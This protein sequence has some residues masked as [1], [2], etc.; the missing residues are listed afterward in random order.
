MNIVE[1][2]SNVTMQK[3][4]YFV[5]FMQNIPLIMILGFNTTIAF[6]SGFRETRTCPSNALEKL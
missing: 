1:G 6:L 3:K 4:E 2:D 5:F